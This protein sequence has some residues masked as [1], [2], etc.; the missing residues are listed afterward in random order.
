MARIFLE[1]GVKACLNQYMF[2]RCSH[3]KRGANSYNLIVIDRKQYR[4]YPDHNHQNPPR[5]FR[6]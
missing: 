4:E 2:H 6:Q 5:F 3:M 1:I